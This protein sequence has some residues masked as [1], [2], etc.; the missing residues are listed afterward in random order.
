VPQFC[1]ILIAFL[2]NL[3]VF[4]KIPAEIENIL[5]KELP[6]AKIRLDNVVEVKDKQWLLIKPQVP[7]TLA[8]NQSITLIEETDKQ[9]FL[10]SNNW[11]YTPIIN[12][13]IK[14]FDFYPESF[15]AVLLKSQIEQEFI[16]PKAFKL[17]RD[18]AMLAGRLP[19]ELDVVELASD[20]E[21]VYKQRLKELENQKPFEVL[22]YSNTD[23]KLALLTIAKDNGSQQFQ[24]IV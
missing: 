8:E 19:L 24:P 4:A 15:Q 9:D 11:I 2:F 3:A 20:R 7:V 12:N 5:L 16:V 10:F 17:P 21:I 14:S 13:S 6:G 23:G 18:L 22:T 1:V